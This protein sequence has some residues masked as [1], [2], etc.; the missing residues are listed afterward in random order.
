M[1]VDFD[2]Y[3]DLLDIRS[4]ERPPNHY[5]LLG[6]E[7]FE[8][9]TS[10]IDEG[11]GRRMALLQELGNSEHQEIS[12]QLLN[13]VSAARRCLLNEAQKIAYDE[14]LRT[15]HKRQSVNR[16]NRQGSK[17]QKKTRRP[18]PMMS[19]GTAAVVVVVL[20]VIYIV[21]RP[22]GA[23]STGNLV[24]DWPLD[25]RQ[26]ATVTLDRKPIELPATQP[27][28][29]KIPDGRHRVVFKRD[30]F[31]DIPQTT[32]FA[33]DVRVKVSLSWVPE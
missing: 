10:I 18:S 14:K 27:A 30:G 17:S 2:A 1:A 16:G 6:I 13:D 32:V 7:V 21:T 28:R 11:A 12:Q 31:R 19:V 23:S 25:E 26:G 33:S 20:L 4:A 15:Q 22:P 9:S 8:S 5:E 3:R 24:V 29:L